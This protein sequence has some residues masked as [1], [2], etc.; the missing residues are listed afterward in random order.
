MNVNLLAPL[1]FVYNFIAYLFNK[2]FNKFIEL[3]QF[4]HSEEVK[5]IL[6]ICFFYICIGVII[7]NIVN[8]VKMAKYKDKNI[9]KYKEYSFQILGFLFIAIF[10]YVVS[11][12]NIL[13]NLIDSKIKIP[14]NFDMLLFIIGVVVFF[15]FHMYDM[16]RNLLKLKRIKN[17]YKDY[18]YLKNNMKYKH[19]YEQYK[20]YR[21]NALSAF[22]I[23]FGGIVSISILLAVVYFIDN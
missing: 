4:L 2:L 23:F 20:K 22:I 13:N 18:I 9:K 6:I 21:W 17:K 15:A 14:N 5:N 1:E 7:Y 19:V 16:I 3:N 11:H 12:D 10:I 8:I